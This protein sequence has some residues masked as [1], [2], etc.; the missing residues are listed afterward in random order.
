MYIELVFS[1]TYFR[2]VRYVLLPSNVSVKRV[3][4]TLLSHAGVSR[5]SVV[6]LCKCET[7][8]IA[9]VFLRDESHV[10]FDKSEVAQT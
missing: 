7:R 5:S 3:S 4:Q 9:L 2:R 1:H 8:C 6:P 10:A